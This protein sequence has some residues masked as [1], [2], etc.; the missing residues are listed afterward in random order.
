MEQETV[1]TSATAAM[2]SARKMSVVLKDAVLGKP[3][4]NRNLEPPVLGAIETCYL[5]HEH[6]DGSTVC[7]E[8]PCK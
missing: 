8:I 1:P 6:E 3:L 2:A 7:H 5:C 4:A